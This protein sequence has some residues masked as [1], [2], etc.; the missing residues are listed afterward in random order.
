MQN[1]YSDEDTART[2]QA[3]HSSA[4]QA[5]QQLIPPTFPDVSPSELPPA[6]LQTSLPAA[7]NNLVALALIAMGV[8]MLLGRLVPSAGELTGGMVLLT[9]ASCFLFFSLW[10]HIYGLLIPGCILGG[11]SIGVAFAG[12]SS[13]VSVL[14]GLALGFL[15]IFLVG[16]ALFKER[17][18]WPIYPS[19][20]LFA[21]GIIV[22]IA[23]L[24]G[25][26]VGLFVWLPLLLV[27]TGLYLGWRRMAY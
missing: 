21:V 11:L 6:S 2:R 15:S 26:F 9:I 19:V 27:A 13:G 24:P 8:V 1:S 5:T 23:N 16:Q 17:S 3:E 20:I 22:A 14:W 12:V 25:I 7:R 18:Q 4:G 10:K